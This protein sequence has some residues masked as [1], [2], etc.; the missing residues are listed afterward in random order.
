MCCLCN[1]Q[2]IGLGFD[3]EAAAQQQQLQTEIRFGRHIPFRIEVQIRT[4]T[5]R[6]KRD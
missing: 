5:A 2:G 6:E 3:R 1:L 4:E